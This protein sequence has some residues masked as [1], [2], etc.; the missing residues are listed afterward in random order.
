MQRRTGHSK[1][2]ADRG[3]TAKWIIGSWP[4]P[5]AGRE[6]SCTAKPGSLR[7]QRNRVRCAHS[8]GALVNPGQLAGVRH[9]AKA[10][11]A[12]SEL[13]EDRV[14]ATATLAAGVRTHRELRLAIGLVDQ[15]FLGHLSSP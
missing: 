5:I 2:T 10:Y 14:R 12:E 6:F 13:A 4:T 7:S 3:P 8:P 11:A 15:C 1:V 9:L